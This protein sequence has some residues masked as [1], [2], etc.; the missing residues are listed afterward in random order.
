MW[1]HRLL[2]LVPRPRKHLH[3]FEDEQEEEGQNY[4]GC[5]RI[6]RTRSCPPL[7]IRPPNAAGQVP[8]LSQVLLRTECSVFRGRFKTSPKYFLKA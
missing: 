1:T 5:C 4:V 6:V 3:R 2:I 8:L 7:N